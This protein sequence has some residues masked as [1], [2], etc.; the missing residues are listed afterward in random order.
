MKTKYFHSITSNYTANT[1]AHSRPD[2]NLSNK[3]EKNRAS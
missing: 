3:K 1:S 2:V